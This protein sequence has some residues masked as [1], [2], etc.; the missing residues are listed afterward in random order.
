MT[1]FITGPSLRTASYS[2][3]EGCHI[4]TSLV[5]EC[6]YPSDSTATGFQV[7]AQLSNISEVQR[8]YVNKTTDQQAPVSVLVEEDGMYLVTIFAIREERGIVDSNVEHRVELYVVNGVV[9]TPPI[10][11][12]CGGGDGGGNGGSGGGKCCCFFSFQ[13]YLLYCFSYLSSHGE[14]QQSNNN[15]LATSTVSTCPPPPDQAKIN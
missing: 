12:G 5:V 10:S 4:H 8:L 7:I 15:R 6:A 13:C 2:F 1:E 14:Q 3:L 9:T 11:T